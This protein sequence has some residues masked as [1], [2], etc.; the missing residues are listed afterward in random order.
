MKVIV[1]MASSKPKMVYHRPGCVYVNRMKPENRMELSRSQAEENGYISCL[2]CGGL[3]G[4]VKTAG[5]QFPAWEKQY[6]VRIDHVKKTDTL[7]VR[8]ENGCWKIF[9]SRKADG[10]YVL[11]HRNFY[12]REMS[13]GQAARGAYHRQSDVR[14]TGSLHNLVDYISKHDKAKQIIMTDYRRLPKATARQKKY[15]RQ[16]ERRIK[17]KER[18]RI[19]GLF[20]QIEEKDPSLKELSFC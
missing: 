1:S 20:R 4:E 12:D 13:L 6:D 3:H 17:R 10:R 8:T 19:D 9:S 16:A 15:Y 18:F 14:P 11:F 7:Y 5:A 2:C